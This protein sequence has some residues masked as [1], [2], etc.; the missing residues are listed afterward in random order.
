MAG[1]GAA[2]VLEAAR[3][4]DASVDWHL[5]EQDPRF[6]GKVQTV[7]RDG[8][9]V[10]GGPDSAIIEKPW[11]ITT[12]REVGI[13]DRF[14]DC[15][16]DIRKSFVFTRGSLH[17]LPEGIILMVPTRMVPFA[18]SRLMTW[19]GK[20]RMGLDLILPRGGAAT[21]GAAGA[22]RPGPRREP[23]RLR[24]P[25]PRQG[26]A[27]AHRRAHRRRHPRRRPRADERARHVPDVPRHGARAPQPDPRDA[28]APQGAPEGRRRS[29]RRRGAPALPARA[30]RRLT[31]ARPEVV[32]LLLQDR[33]PGPERRHRRVAAGRPAARRHRRHDHD[34][35]RRR[36]RRARRVR[37]LRAAA[38]RRHARGRRRRRARDAGLGERRP[39]ARRS[40]RSPPP[41]SRPSTT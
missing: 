40:R 38:Q 24:A 9:V 41:T 23:R 34:R 10:E 30:R 6:G 8:F 20:M 15:N 37:R 28:Q 19:P 21:A 27:A 18:M 7:R 16:E 26:G 29:R 17:E 33:A 22:R 31:P 12:A 1:L 32:L 25:P 4:Q 13:G 35:V 14:L 2:R 5:Y 3:A 39:A 36:L 11:P